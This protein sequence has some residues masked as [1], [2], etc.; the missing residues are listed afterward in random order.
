MKSHNCQEAMERL[1]EFLDRELSNEE[2]LEVHQ[3]LER[4]PPCREHFR[5][6][7]NVL[8]RIGASCRKVEAPPELV[9]RVRRLCSEL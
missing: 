5:F 3:H 2:Q 6:E 9:E 4:C 7:E 1:F 8:R